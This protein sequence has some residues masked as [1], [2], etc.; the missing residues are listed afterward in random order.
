MGC[1]QSRTKTTDSIN[2]PDNDIETVEQIQA[3]SDIDNFA[4]M[5]AN[6]FQ[7]NINTERYINDIE[8]NYSEL[9]VKILALEEVYYDMVKEIKIAKGNLRLYD[10]KIKNIEKRFKTGMIAKRLVTH[11]KDGYFLRSKVKNDKEKA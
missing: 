2:T 1:I 6:S 11:T 3:Y 9:Q 4:M 7:Y 8:S 5:Q 10:R